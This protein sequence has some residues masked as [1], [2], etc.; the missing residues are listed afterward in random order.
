MKQISLN[1]AKS[2]ALAVLIPLFTPLVAVAQEMYAVFN[3]GTLTFYYDNLRSSRAGVTYNLNSGNNH[4]AWY[5]SNDRDN[6]KNVVF[7]NSF[8]DARPTSAYEWFRRC[9]NLISID[10]S[11]LNTSCIT[12]MSAMFAECSSLTSLDLSRFDTSNVTDMSSM[13]SGCSAL[14]TLDISPL[15][16]SNVTDMRYMFSNCKGL[17]SLDLSNFKTNNVVNISGLFSG[18]QGLTSLDLRSFNTANVTDM[19]FMFSTCL[20]LTSL[21]L[22]NF[23]TNNVTDMSG[24]FS[25]CSGLTSLDI[26]HFN[27]SNVTNMSSMFSNCSSLT[28][29]DISSL[30]TSNVTNLGSMFLCCS[31]LTTLDLSRFNTTNVTKMGNMFDRCSSLVSLDLSPLNTT[32]VTDMN[33][34]FRS[35]SSLTSLDL[36]PLKTDNVMSMDGMFSGCSG[37]TSLDLS[38]LNTDNVTNTSSMFSGCSGLTSLDLSPLNT[39]NVL[40]MSYMFMD[41]SGLTSLDLSPLNTSKVIYMG[42]MFS[43]CSNLKSLDVSPFNI[44]SVIDLGQMF[45]NCNSLTTIY[46]GDEWNTD[47][48]TSSTWMFRNCTSL[49]GEAGTKYDGIHMDKA[50]AHIDG[51]ASNPGY[52]SSKSAVSIIDDID[53]L[54]AKLD[55]IAARGTSTLENPEAIN[56][57]TDIVINK[58]LFVRNGCHAVLTGAGRL[59]FTEEV[60]AES[61]ILITDE[62]SLNLDNFDFDTNSVLSATTKQVFCIDWKS[63][64]RFTKTFF[65]YYNAGLSDKSVVYLNG[66]NVTFDDLYGSTRDLTIVKGY[67][68]VIVDN[69]KIVVSDAPV[70]DGMDMIITLNNGYMDGGGECVVRSLGNSVTI[71]GGSVYGTKPSSIAIDASST[72]YNGGYVGGKTTIC[73]WGQIADGDMRFGVERI[74]FKSNNLVGGTVKLPIL[75]LDKDKFEYIIVESALQNEW[76]IDAQWSEFPLGKKLIY[77]SEYRNYKQL[78]KADYEKMTFLNM[79]SNREAYYDETDCS[80]KLR[81]RTVD[82]SD[83]LQDFIDGLGDNKGTEEEPVNVPVG[84]DG[85]TIDGNVDVDD[86]LQLF[87]DGGSDGDTFLPIRYAGGFICIFKNCSFAFN[88]VAMAGTPSMPSGSSGGIKNSGKLKL[89]NSTVDDGVIVNSG[90]L[91]VDGN[92][93]IGSMHHKLGGR[94]Y[95]TGTLT[96]DINIS[97]VDASDVELYTPIVLGGNGYT[98]SSADADRIH[99]SLPEGFEWKYDSTSGSVMV[100]IASGI[101]QIANEQPTVVGTYDATGRSIDAKSKGLHIQRMSDGT[102]RKH[103]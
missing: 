96:N 37:L 68:R 84:D 13:F 64:L 33:A 11:Y 10:L 30:N 32:N 101:S 78:T 31:K 60:A 87:I 61:L 75:E 58:Q 57:S 18:C 70:I 27:T 63:S 82:S 103:F 22:S 86:D 39:S 17:T 91:Y 92:V 89:T 88:H 4:P 20:S 74:I 40:Y 15:N 90:G 72:N 67:G 45:M 56:L 52:F 46:C 44:N 73:S 94:I 100:I 47:N 50:Y 5:F 42:A 66:G 83:D 3:D 12:N 93:S 71:N 2:V 51:G 81:E 79:P 21:D 49:V 19:S 53:D 29:L 25:G 76:Q 26:S 34:M 24:M 48:V 9:K 28:S 95:V 38:P 85:L 35:C 62:S 23:N 69:G 8:K 36:S 43:G 16:T 80:V 59:R 102:V 41:C 1:R 77:A 97:I 55:E 7:D 14:A 65:N 99:L 6:I 54:Q 98:L